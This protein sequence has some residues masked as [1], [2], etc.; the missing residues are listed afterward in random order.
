M[1][2]GEKPQGGPC[3]REG[4]K[5]TLSPP[6][7]FSRDLPPFSLFPNLFSLSVPHQLVLYS[8]AFIS[9]LELM[10]F[11]LKFAFLNGF[12][13]Y[14]VLTS[15]FLF[16]LS[17]CEHEY[18]DVDE[19]QNHHSCNNGT[20]QFVLDE[21]IGIKC[22]LCSFVSLEIR[23]IPPVMATEHSDRMFG[24]PIWG[25]QDGLPQFD[26]LFVSENEEMKGDG[27][28]LSKGTVW[29]LI[30]GVRSTLYPHQQ[31]AFEFMWRNLAGDIFLNNL[32]GSAC[33]DGL[34]GCVISHAPGTGK[35]RLTIVFIQ[36]FLG[37]FP[38]C[39]PV[40]VAPRGM[41][42]T[43]KKEF[44]KW[45]I[46]IPVHVLNEHQFS[47][48]E[49]EFALSLVLG[50]KRKRH[51]SRIVKLFSWDK[52]RSIL[53][54]SYCLFEKLV[55]SLNKQGTKNA[56]LGKILLDKPDL[57]VFDEGHTPRN[58]RSLIW[59]ALRKIR[60]ERRIIL[61]GTPFQNNFGELY[62]TFCLVRPKF[63]DRISC[64][65]PQNG[66]RKEFMMENEENT[67][68]ARDEGRG[69]WAS[70]TSS[71]TD[72][73]LEELRLMMKPFVHVHNGSS[74][75]CLPGLKDCLI[76]LDPLPRQKSVLEVVE[77]VRSD[78]TFAMEYKTCLAS[79]HPSLL[80]A[81]TLSEKESSEIDIRQ[82]ESIRLN[83]NEGVK[84]RFVMELV[85][86]CQPLHERVLVFSQYIEPLDLIVKQ[87]ELP[88]GWKEGTDILKMDGKIRPRHRQSL[89]D[90]FNDSKSKARVLLASIKACCE[91]ISL[92]GASRVVLL[93]VVWNP[94]VERQ[95]ISRAYRLGQEK[96]VY[97]YH[98][99]TYGTREGDKYYK[100][101]EKDRLSK[102]VF[103]SADGHKTVQD[104]SLAV[105][106]DKILKEMVGHEK[107]QYMFK[108]IL[109]QP[110]QSNLID[111]FMF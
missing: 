107:L 111:A 73:R 105:S 18:M 75:R 92:T 28:E 33:Y 100:Q 10:I 20:H 39:R 72:E 93:D 14:Y 91:G 61:S 2:P 83:P 102:L 79:V 48:T 11:T 67:P 27:F 40:I 81:C 103:S 38:E 65:K 36:A 70:L 46:D 60:T 21:Q 55:G 94:S 90:A 44:E 47:G 31:E 24:R 41:L 56:Y 7:P 69:K 78:T 76:V 15:S 89:I 64:E 26:G 87:L 108:R 96:V 22:K 49:D 77:D 66:Q 68:L 4:V 54:L 52:G 88:F 109:Y 59:K 13:I 98:L 17:D 34:G 82:L 30:P 6:I 35:S 110:K 12:H 57:F 80:T 62:N 51:W 86:L 85:R 101:V 58:E 63:A 53:A 19:D 43:W 8:L 3:E 1:P 37:V 104:D 32:K 97:I 106:E 99:I 45:K 84:T 71:I 50:V 25:K 23:Y 9:T 5:P 95:A 16:D 42:L 74:L 29:D